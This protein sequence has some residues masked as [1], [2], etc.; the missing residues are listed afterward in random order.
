MIHVL[1]TVEL[2]SG[3]R[4]DFLSEFHKIVPLVRQEKG[5]VEY[6]PAI[7]TAT[8]ISAQG[9]LRENVVVVIEKWENLPALEAHL[10]APHMLEYRGK[11]K[12]MVV[13]TQ[14]QIL[15]PA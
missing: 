7:D 3:R 2:K 13:R 11:V 10:I 14:L 6:G 5:C 4:E 8:D 15:E 12:E 1:A 9:R